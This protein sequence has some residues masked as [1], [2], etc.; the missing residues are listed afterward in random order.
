[1]T[2]PPA[3][4][5]AD[6]VV[7]G[8]LRPV[9]T[10]L[11]QL[12]VAS[13]WFLAAWLVTLPF[14]GDSLDP[15]ASVV[16]FLLALAGGLTLISAA[17]NLYLIVVLAGAVLVLEGGVLRVPLSPWRTM[18]LEDIVGVRVQNLIALPLLVVSL[19]GGRSA[20]FYTRFMTPDA[21]AMAAQLTRLIA[22]PR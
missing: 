3:T 4:R 20:T 18:R 6:R 10:P 11:F 22:A 17:V 7:I 16:A 9:L 21:G 5:P 8:R 19:R 13:G 15:R 2:S 1:V 14:G 12:A